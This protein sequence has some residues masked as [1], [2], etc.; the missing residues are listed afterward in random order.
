MDF[1]GC[2]FLEIDCGFREISKRFRFIS[3]YQNGKLVLLFCQGMQ[4]YIT[5]QAASVT[6]TFFCKVVYCFIRNISLKLSLTLVGGGGL[7]DVSSIS[8]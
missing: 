2:P 1:C 4:E 6:I 8:R 3:E 5:D 7:S